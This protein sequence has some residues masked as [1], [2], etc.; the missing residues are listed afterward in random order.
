MPRPGHSIR[1]QQLLKPVGLVE[2]TAEQHVPHTIS[3]ASG[4]PASVQSVGTSQRAELPTPHIS[5]RFRQLVG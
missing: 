5:V 4:S 2:Q 1:R 3:K